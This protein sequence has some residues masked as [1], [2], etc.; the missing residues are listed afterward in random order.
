MQSVDASREGSILARAKEAHPAGMSVVVIEE[1]AKLSPRLH[2]ALAASELVGRVR[3]VRSLARS[4]ALVRRE[5][6]QL[7]ILPCN[8][9][10]VQ[11]YGFVT[12]LL[13]IAPKIHIVLV[14]PPSVSGR[15]LVHA[16][17][18]GT[19]SLLRNNARAEELLQSLKAIREGGSWFSPCLAAAL[20]GALR[21]GAQLDPRIGLLSPRQREVLEGLGHGLTYQQIACSLH[22]RIDTVRSHIKQLYRNLGLRSR[23]DAAVLVARLS[24]HDHVTG[25]GPK[26]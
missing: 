21:N 19:A 20:A 11:I 14:A 7:A 9:S 1:E 18:Q 25:Q 23:N 6:T 13:L 10:A 5:E 22:V 12:K 26:Q 8:T 2:L 4:G 16:I 17:Q 3:R 15:E 24:S